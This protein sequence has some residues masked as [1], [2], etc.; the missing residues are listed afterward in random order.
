VWK[1]NPG[2]EP[3]FVTAHRI[4]YAGQVNPGVEE[5]SGLGT[6]L[7]HRPQDQLR[8]PGKKHVLKRSCYITVDPETPAAE[9]G[10]CNGNKCAWHNALVSQ[11]TALQ[12][13]VKV[14]CMLL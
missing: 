5:E 1:K 14:F 9:N 3:D 12:L 4:N 13:K 6:G 7:C 10:I 8:R 11:L 2:W